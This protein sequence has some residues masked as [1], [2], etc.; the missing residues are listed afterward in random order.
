MR[1]GI[2]Y[3]LKAAALAA[4][5]QALDAVGKANA[6]QKSLDAQ[7]AA[8]DATRQQLEI[9]RQQFQQKVATLNTVLSKL[10]GLPFT[11]KR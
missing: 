9:Q 10:S 8:L 11:P 5:T 4:N 6:Q 2:T 7:L 1:I 3:D